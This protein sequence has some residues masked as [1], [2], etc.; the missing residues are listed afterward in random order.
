MNTH[1]CVEDRPHRS[2]VQNNPRYH[3]EEN[4]D[5]HQLA[6]LRKNMHSNQSHYLTKNFKDRM[7]SI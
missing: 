1:R 6:R 4:V 3:S 5:A 7:R 2:A